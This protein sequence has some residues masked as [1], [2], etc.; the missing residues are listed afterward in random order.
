MILKVSF[1]AVNY[2]NENKKTL[3]SPPNKIYKLSGSSII[4]ISSG[5]DFNE[6]VIDMNG[7]NGYLN[8][9]RQGIQTVYESDSQLIQDLKAGAILTSTYWDVLENYP[10]TNNSFLIIET[11][12]PYYTYRGTLTYRTEFNVHNRNGSMESPLILPLDPQYITKITCRK[13]PD[14]IV[15]YKNLVI[16]IGENTT[17][18]RLLNIA[19]DRCV[20]EGIS[21]KQGDVVYT[22]HPTYVTIN[23]STFTNLINFNAEFPNIS[24]NGGYTYL[25][26]MTHTYN[27]KIEK[28][29]GTGDG[30]G[31]TGSNLCQRTTFNN[32]TLS[33]IDFHNPSIEYLRIIDCDIGYWGVLCTTIGDVDIRGGSFIFSN[34][35]TRDSQSSFIM[36]RSELRGMCYGNLTIDGTT[37]YNFTDRNIYILYHSSDSN[38][39]LPE[40]SPLENIFW[41]S[42]TIK[43]IK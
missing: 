12:Q 34:L 25:L 42:V 8:F 38:D 16:N 32:C 3:I 5:I 33:R 17:T 6:S 18:N 43:N 30:W 28:F 22:T 14:N 39:S 20:V 35:S 13:L 9:K 10:E 31:S 19:C 2:A 15:Y 37:F 29:R 36:S 27:V 7:F 11:N 4:D 41:K 21:F 24:S 40:N 23:G 1:L 26:E